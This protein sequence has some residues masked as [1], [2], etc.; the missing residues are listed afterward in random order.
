MFTKVKMQKLINQKTNI[1]SKFDQTFINQS[2]DYQE[3]IKQIKVLLKHIRM[4]I[5]L[6]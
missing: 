2:G 3:I 5:M 4:K 1:S 6:S